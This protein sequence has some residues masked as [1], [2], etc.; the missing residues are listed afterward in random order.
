M[1]RAPTAC[2]TVI[3]RPVVSNR[4]PLLLGF[5]I[6]IGPVSVDMYLPAFPAIA[7]DF[8]DAAAPGLTLAAYFAGLALGQMTQGP[9][10]DRVGRRLPV[11]LGLSLYTVASLGCA[12][13]WSTASLSAFRLLAAFGGSASV[14][15]P[16]AMV[17]DV[18]DGPAAAMLF[19]KLMLVMGV[20]P[21][22]APILGSA[23]V[24]VGSWR[25][26]FGLAAL[27]GV[28]A[29]ALVWFNL[30]DTLPAARRSLI[31]FRSI[32]IRYGQI[33]A[34]RSFLAHALTGTFAIGA[35]FAYLAG[36]PGVFIGDFGWSPPAYAALFAANAAVYI[37]FNQWNPHLVARVGL[38]PV[39]T[40][41]I[42]LLLIGTAGLTISAV[43]GT[44]AAAIIG[45]LFIC[46]ASYG[47]ALPST[48]VAALSRHQPHAGSASA[49]MGTWQYLGGAITGAVVG[50][51]ADGTARPMA[52]AML[53]CAILALLAGAL[54]PATV[55]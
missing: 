37:G 33:A 47:F 14:V 35:L 38:R 15:I 24:S 9:F 31:G 32:L 29:L 10:S 40:A 1:S 27:Y 36:T 42:V 16:R 45:C 48:M 13:A 44:G 28:I 52:M 50:G 2:S 51:F 34:E 30:P 41:S 25:W 54:R 17:R 26:I 20:A 11:L 21:I 43:V 19:S 12:L 46:Q 23:V 3:A 7:H 5:L 55:L 49:L 6:A 8:R 22:V 18:A 39:I 4:L 53:G